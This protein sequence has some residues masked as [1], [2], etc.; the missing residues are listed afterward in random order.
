[1][2]EAAPAVGS[3][4]GGSSVMASVTLSFFACASAGQAVNKGKLAAELASKERRL[5]INKVSDGARPAGA[6]KAVQPMP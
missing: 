4:P 2:D 3:S 6:Q 5:S 1:M